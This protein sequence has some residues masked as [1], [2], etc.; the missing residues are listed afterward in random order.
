MRILIALILFCSPLIAGSNSQQDEINQ[1]IGSLANR[2]RIKSLNI[3]EA[4]EI[5]DISFLRDFPSL[6]SLDLNGNCSIGDNYHPITE[7]KHLRKLYIAGVSFYSLDPIATL[8]DLTVL[9][10]SDNPV[11]SIAPLANLSKLKILDI[12]FSTYIRD[13]EVIGQIT[14]LNTLLMHHVY[15]QEEIPYTPLNNYMASLVKLHELDISS[16]RMLNDINILSQLPR[17]GILNVAKCMYLKDYRCLANIKSLKD[18]TIPRVWDLPHGSI[19]P[20]FP[21]TVRVHYPP[22][23][24]S[25]ST[26]NGT[27]IVLTRARRAD[28]DAQGE[29]DYYGKHSIAMETQDVKSRKQ[30]MLGIQYSHLVS[31]IRIPSIHHENPDSSESDS[32]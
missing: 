31:I 15:I 10:I 25:Q 24:E 2:D 11:T 23:P 26:S 32:D 18:L 17:L 20:Q 1:Y 21:S 8:T 14:S 5:I 3:T 30:R 12:S 9:N 7:L 19:M 28:A 29:V 22:Y 6:T 16:N 4:E 13:L 27:A